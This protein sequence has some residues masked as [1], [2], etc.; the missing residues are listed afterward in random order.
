MLP[1]QKAV[2]PVFVDEDARFEHAPRSAEEVQ[3]FEEM[4]D[5]V[6]GIQSGYGLTIR[7]S[8][9][10]TIT[11]LELESRDTEAGDQLKT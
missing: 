9:P 11:G 6:D 10:L 5:N 3:A 8:D 7:P 1:L 2:H 4:R